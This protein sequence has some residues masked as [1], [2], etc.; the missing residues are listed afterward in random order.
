M[1]ERRAVAAVMTHRCNL[2]VYMM[3]QLTS[4]VSNEPVAAADRADSWSDT[5]WYL[6]RKARRRWRKYVPWPDQRRN[7]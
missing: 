7:G 5:P 1:S 2:C 6:S 3:A 4:N